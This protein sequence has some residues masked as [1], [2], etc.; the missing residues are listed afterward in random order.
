MPNLDRFLEYTDKTKRDDFDGYSLDQ[1][2]N[3]IMP[4]RDLIEKSSKI[5]LG[6]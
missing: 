2:V 6:W 1:N 5:E 3:D 4:I